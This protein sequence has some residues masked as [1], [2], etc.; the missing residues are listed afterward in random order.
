MSLAAFRGAGP[1][2]EPDP[3]FRLD[4]SRFPQQLDLD[5]PEHLVAVLERRAQRCNRSLSELI[6]F[7]IADAA[8]ERVDGI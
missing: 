7:L 5:L 6:E 4:P 2:C 8:G 3:R 1:P